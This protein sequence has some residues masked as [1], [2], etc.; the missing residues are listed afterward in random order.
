M[1]PGRWRSLLRVLAWLRREAA[2]EPSP[3]RGEDASAMATT[4]DPTELPD[5]V[6]IYRRAHLARDLDTA[7]ATYATHATV[8][9]EGPHLPRLGPDPGWLARSAGEYAF[10]ILL[11]GATRLDDH[12]Y[13]AR[14]HLEG[15]FPAARSTGTSGSR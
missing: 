4:I 2:D 7:V 14:Y 13:D 3:S 11:I 15:N 1:R 12:H 10:T 9:D 5:I 8:T 6:T